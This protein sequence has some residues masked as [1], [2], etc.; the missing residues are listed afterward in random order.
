MTGHNTSSDVR[1]RAALCL[2]R[3]LRATPEIP[4]PEEWLS[5]ISDLLK[6]RSLGVV[7]SVM[8]LV[9][10]VLE[11]TSD[12]ETDMLAGRIIVLLQQLV[13]IGSCPGEYLYK[14]IP[15]PWLQV[16][17]LRALSLMELPESSA[18]KARLIDVLSRILSRCPEMQKCINRN[19]SN[20]SILFEAIDLIVKHGDDLD[21]SLKIKA[22]SL[23]GRYIQ[24]RDAN[25]RYLGLTMMAKLAASGGAG[26]YIKK[27]QATILF[28]LKDPD[29]SIRKRALNLLFL[30]CD[31]SNSL[32]VVKELLSH[33]ANADISIREEMVLKIAILAER[34]APNYKWYI[35]TILFIIKNSG[36][37]I[38][39]NIWHR[40]CQIVSNQEDLQSYAAQTMFDAVNEKQVN[41]MLV[42]AASYILGEYVCFNHFIISLKLQE[43]QRSNTGTEVRSKATDRPRTYSTKP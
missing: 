21:K 14:K 16:K 23:L 34:Y 1:K 19:N 43:Y 29:I 6:H 28:G 13:L 18:D 15:C 2:N 32:V 35:D 24:I 37:V 39:D 12:I 31:K 26:E 10:G 4:F 33:L 41:E 20:H 42:R 11:G 36:N 17:L 9:L 3:V 8:A 5:P 40:A 27:H 7:I 25:M 30:M 22:S 38:D